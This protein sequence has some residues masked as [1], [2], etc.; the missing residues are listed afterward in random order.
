M[1]KAGRSGAGRAP[2][3]ARLGDRRPAL[4]PDLPPIGARPTPYL[5]PIGARPT[6]LVHSMTHLYTTFFRLDYENTNEKNILIF[7][8]QRI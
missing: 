2:I 8:V 7:Q 1:D 3:G 4:P 6:C 5:P